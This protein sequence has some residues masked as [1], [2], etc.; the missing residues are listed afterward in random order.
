[1]RNY[2]WDL[3]CKLF[4][5]VLRQR[6]I[7]FRKLFNVFLCD[8]AF[9]LKFK[10]GSPAPY[11]LSLELWNECNA[12]CLFCRDKK[13]KIHDFN[14]H[15]TGAIPKGKMLPEMAMDIIRQLKDD[16]LIAV[17]YTNGEP[18]LYEDLP[19]VI[20]WATDHRVATMIATNGLLFNEKNARELLASGI[21][22]IKIQLSGFTQDIYGIQIRY[23]EVERLKENIRMLTRIKREDGYQTV[24]L[25]D[26]ILYNYNRHQLKLV[27]QFC[28]ELDLMM[29]VR[30]GNPLGGLEDS[31]PPLSDEPLPLKISCDYLWKV[32][33][34][35]YNGDILPCCEA[36]VWSHAKPYETFE[37]GRTDVRKVWQGKAARSMRE[38]MNDHGR[39][40]TVM[41]AQCTRRGVCFKW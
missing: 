26:Y 15:G 41:C 17:L 19:G 20:Q 33:Q 5:R 4:L 24:I 34:V 37:T 38:K 28:K 35:N 9:L 11:I 25:I 32:L 18:L 36:V 1:M 7:S 6:K 16:I 22:L 2:Y 14:P 8:C 30:P 23:G 21:D 10:K 31:E 12:G 27:R 39:A 3:Q 13:G 40:A 29:N